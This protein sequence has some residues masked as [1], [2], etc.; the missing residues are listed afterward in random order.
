MK[1]QED[2]LLAKSAENGLLSL[3][4]HT[5]HVVQ[6]AVCFAKA[7]G[8]DKVTARWAALIHDMG[9]AHPTFQKRVHGLESDWERL[10]P[11]KKPHRH[12]VSSLAFLPTVPKALWVNVFAAVVA[13]HKSLRHDSRG[14]GLYD[15]SG[16]RSMDYSFS[17]DE[18]L[19]SHHLDAQSSPWE[20][21]HLGA[22]EV[23]SKLTGLS[24]AP[25]ARADAKQALHWA[26]EQ[27]EAACKTPGP[28]PWKGLL[29][30]A[31][32]FASALGHGTA[33]QLPGQFKVP[34]WNALNKRSAPHP[35]YPLSM[36]DTS[37][38]KP[39]TLVMA[40]TGA[41]KT[42]YLLR[43][44]RGR[45]FY[46]LPFQAS[47]NAM[48]DRLS[49]VLAGQDVQV[50]LLHAA[51]RLRPGQHNGSGGELEADER[52][53]QDKAGAG[54]KVL[55]PHQMMG[56]V[57]ATRGYEALLMDVR[58]CDVILDEIHT[59]GE[60]AQAILF[61]LVEVLAHEGCRLHIGSATMPTALA[62]KVMNALGGEAN[63]HIE[64]L[65]EEELA[66]YDRHTVHKLASWE[67]GLAQALAYAKDGKKVLVVCNR[68]AHA[69]AAFRELAP[70][71]GDVEAML[72]HSRYKRA[73]RAAKEKQLMEWGKGKAPCLA[74]ATQVG[75]GIPGHLL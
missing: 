49:E 47:I 55:T 1:K 65:G 75:R 73:D 21:W 39:H 4:D 26:L 67:D 22:L 25:I 31:D 19:I 28:N 68:V 11:N 56:L 52:A 60:A 17:S 30:A 10:N 48:F 20:A 57:M 74:V 64:L 44:T 15:L 71:L 3:H 27:S 46:T 54:L 32:H 29:V 7:V 51:S 36:R 41:G 8:M 62:Q 13:H 34:D 9:K 35:L 23:L 72:I 33:K 53:L 59:Y 14:L 2:E 69:Q 12:E 66:T 18:S 45:V 16:D 58:G 63:V 61:R 38:P 40:P 43:R 6:A 50:R 5:Q 42:E 24:L 37:S 70:Q